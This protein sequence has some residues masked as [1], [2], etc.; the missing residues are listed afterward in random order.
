M[1]TDE[2]R[3]GACHAGRFET[4]VVAAE[5]PGAVREILRL[6]LPPNPT[7]LSKKIREGARTFREAGGDRAYFGDPAA[8]TPEEGRATIETLAEILVTA[9][10][11][12]SRA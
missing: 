9:I 12:A 5:R 7:S 1:L 6:T 11:E 4:S 3:S 2:F 8:A 10:A